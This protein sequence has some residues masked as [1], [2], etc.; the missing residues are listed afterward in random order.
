MSSHTRRKFF[1][2]A[3]IL[4]GGAALASM[5]GRRLLAQD[6][7]E[8]C[9]P[10]GTQPTPT[11]FTPSNNLPMRTRQSAFALS[12]TDQAKLVAAYAALR[13]LPPDDPRGWLPQAHVHCWYCSGSQNYPSNVEIHGSWTF[14]PWHRCYLYFHERILA[15]LIGDDTFAL[16]Y[17]AWE[18]T[19]NPTF[20][21]LYAVNPSSLYDPVRAA[22]PSTTPTITQMFAANG[23]DVQAR[24]QETSKTLFLGNAGSGGNIEFGP[25]GDVHLWTADPS[26]N[27]EDSNP[28]MGILQTAA[29]DPVFFAHHGNIDRLWWSWNKEGN[30][31]YTD[32]SWLDISWTFYDE[33][34]NWIS[35]SVADVLDAEN[36]LH[37]TYDKSAVDSSSSK[38]FLSAAATM[39]TVKQGPD[40]T[41]TQ[42]AVPAAAQAQIAEVA[43]RRTFILHIDGVDV[44]PDKAAM[45]RVFVNMPTAT[46]KTLAAQTPNFV[47]TFTIVPSVVKGNTAHN[48]KKRNIVF[49]VS[50][51]LATVLKGQKNISVTLVPVSR[52]NQRHENIQLTYDKVYIT[53]E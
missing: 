4:A 53:I 27:I 30:A 1:R 29:R 46:P 10:P 18:V 52:L 5:P 50:R 42:I 31:N 49:D 37:Y 24:L 44:P 21:P 32:S 3:G 22:T 47:G 11:P 20:P 48:H 26:L 2:D 51:Q 35:I 7:N 38:V 43:P 36:N 8:N 6:P 33:N 39:A 34:K 23:V 9:A 16:P 28:D 25:H 13:A 41:T 19:T 45:V 17:W 12:T 15:T 14:M 40:P